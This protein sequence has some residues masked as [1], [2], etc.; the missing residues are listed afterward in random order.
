MVRGE[1]P[2]FGAASGRDDPTIP[3]DAGPDGVPAYHDALLQHAPSQIGSG[4]HVPHVAGQASFALT[5][6]SDT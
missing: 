1:Y 4:G 3:Q 6:P 2:R 5:P